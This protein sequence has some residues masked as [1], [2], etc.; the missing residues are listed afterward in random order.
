MEVYFKDLISAESS[1]EKLVD[2]ISLV[3][4]GVDDFARAVGEN[5]PHEERDQILN[6]L[7]RLRQSCVRLKG[8]IIGGA[9]ATDRA[10]RL[11][12]YSAIS[13]AFALGCLIGVILPRHR[14]GNG[15]DE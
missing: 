12:P 3:V 8:Q 15:E 5:L 7:N 6:R 9:R 10:L 14:A 13:M 2:D 4:Q 1:L 11:H